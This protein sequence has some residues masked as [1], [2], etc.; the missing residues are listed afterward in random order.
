MLIDVNFI[1]LKLWSLCFLFQIKVPR[2]KLLCVQFP[3]II[4]LFQ[5]QINDSS[6]LVTNQTA[7][8]VFV[9]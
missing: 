4:Y 3:C 1:S 5:I 2:P 6:Q 9:Y 8:K 7:T